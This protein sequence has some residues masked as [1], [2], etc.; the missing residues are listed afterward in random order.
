VRSTANHFGK[1]GEN[2]IL[3]RKTPSGQRRRGTD[4]VDLTEEGRRLA[5]A[6]R[7]LHAIH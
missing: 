3:Y 1:K 6:Y 2:A 5:A 7:R 4:L